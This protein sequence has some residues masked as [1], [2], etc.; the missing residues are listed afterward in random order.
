MASDLVSF[1][2]NVGFVISCVDVVSGVDDDEESFSTINDA[3]AI[4]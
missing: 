1:A 4:D 3:A 2:S